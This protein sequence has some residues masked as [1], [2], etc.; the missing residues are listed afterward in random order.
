MLRLTACLGMRWHNWG[1]TEI[2]D[3]IV[4]RSSASGF[5]SGKVR[6][7]VAP[8]GLALVVLPAGQSMY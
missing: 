4:G 6:L 1:E 8:G 2:L 7:A 3:A 5:E